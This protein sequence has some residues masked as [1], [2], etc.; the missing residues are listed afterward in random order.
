MILRVSIGLNCSR[1]IYLSWGCVRDLLVVH[2]GKERLSIQQD[3]EILA[4]R[5]K[6][7]EVAKKEIDQA[8]NDL[9][10]REIKILQVEPLLPLARQLQELSLGFDDIIPWIEMI[11]EKA[12]I[13]NI[14]LKTAAYNVTHELREYRQL[15]GLHKAAEQVKQ[16]LAVLDAFTA[17]KQQA[18]TTLMNLQMAGFSEKDIMELTGLANK[19]SGIGSLGLSQGNSSSSSMLP[20]AVWFKLDDKLIGVGH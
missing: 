20:K 10:I 3:K 18:V 15:G 2:Y 8:R 14:D 5:E 9:D 7:L 1:Y 19:W 6:Y 4:R 11:R 17:Q 16:Q 13:E 12:H